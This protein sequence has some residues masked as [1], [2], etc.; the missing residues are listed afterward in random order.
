MRKDN[1]RK[2]STS[3]IRPT[4]AVK[5]VLLFLSGVVLISAKGKDCAPS[6]CSCK[7]YEVH[8]EMPEDANKQMTYYE[9][10]AAQCKSHGGVLANLADPDVD[11]MLKKFIANE[12][13]DGSA[14]INNFGFFIGLTDPNYDGSFVWSNG[15]PLCQG[16][17]TNWAPGEPNNNDK[18]DENGQNCGQLWYRSNHNGLWDDEYCNERPK[19]YVCEIPN[20]CC[21]SETP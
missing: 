2:R 21:C 3:K 7:K 19:G 4:M 9:Y 16:C 1:I 8:C 15:N 14:C 6:F 13:L 17:Y 18:K 11:A 12:G 5:L 10:A 20:N